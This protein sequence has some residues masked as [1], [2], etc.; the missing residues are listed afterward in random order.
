MTEN[1]YYP[2]AVRCNNCENTYEIDIPTG[3]N[4]EDVK[5]KVCGLKELRKSMPNQF[6][7]DPTAF[8]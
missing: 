5:C 8:I 4:Y 3:T 1:N 7:I 6:G 2:V